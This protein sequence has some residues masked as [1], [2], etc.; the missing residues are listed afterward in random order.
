MGTELVTATVF[1]D[2]LDLIGF[3]GKDM[4]YETYLLGRCEVFC[5][6]V[7]FLGE[8]MHLDPG[9]HLLNNSAVIIG[10]PLYLK[11]TEMSLFVGFTVTLTIS[12][13]SY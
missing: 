1:R 11:V 8:G 13:I 10:E 5:H 7:I 12:E 2:E 4:L 9:Y 3:R 6:S